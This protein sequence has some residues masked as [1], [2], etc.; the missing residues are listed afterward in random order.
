MS[1]SAI[2]SSAWAYIKALFLHPAH[3]FKEPLGLW[4]VSM[5]IADLQRGGTDGK[6]LDRL[7]GLQYLK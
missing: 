7:R 1:I 2:I 3:L 4:L 6:K 5:L